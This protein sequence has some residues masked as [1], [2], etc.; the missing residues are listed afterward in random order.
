MERIEQGIYEA[1]QIWGDGARNLVAAF[2]VEQKRM[3]NVYDILKY[4]RQ[5]I[6]DMQG[7]RHGFESGGGTN[8]S[9]SG[10]SRKF[11]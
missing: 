4:D 8:F 1:S 6:R 10:A 5:T 2:E 3:D 11:F 9:A 7:R